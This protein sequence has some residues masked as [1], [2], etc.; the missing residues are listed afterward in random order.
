MP[1]FKEQ[2]E[3]V[4]D[5]LTLDAFTRIKPEHDYIMLSETKDEGDAQHLHP[6]SAKVHHHKQYKVV[7]N[8]N[9]DMTVILK[10]EDELKDAWK[11]KDYAAN[12]VMQHLITK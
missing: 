9:K 1:N 8:S 5:R 7:Y 4:K 6:N 10:F 12:K 11:E 3:L 2:V